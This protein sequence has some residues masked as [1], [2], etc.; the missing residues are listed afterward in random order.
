MKIVGAS[1]GILAMGLLTVSLYALA[2]DKHD[3]DKVVQLEKKQAVILSTQQ[4]LDANQQQ[5]IKDIGAIKESIV[6]LES[7]QMTPDV[8]KQIIREAGK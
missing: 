2:A 6:R 8:F 7:K 3:K 1:V 4:K 5:I